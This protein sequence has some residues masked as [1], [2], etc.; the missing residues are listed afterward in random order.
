MAMFSALCAVVP[1][2]RLFCLHVDHGLRAEESKGDAEFV[3]DFCE[4][5]GIGCRVESI[6]HGKIEFYAQHKGI[7]IE[8]A[9][10]H[11]R[12]R[13]LFREAARLGDNTLILIAHTKD[14]LLETALMRVLRGAGPAGL[15][16]MPEKRGRILRPVLS[17]SRS[18]I[19]NYLSEKKIPWRED[20]TNTDEVFLRNKVRRRLVPLLDEFFP[21]WKSGLTGMAATQSLAADYLAGEAKRRIVWEQNKNS[22]STGEENFFAQDIIIREE[23]LFQGVDL[24]V[25][26]CKKI[27]ASS[28]VPK[29]SVV[30]R[31]CAGAVAAADLGLLRVRRKNGVIVLS[32]IRR[33]FS[34]SGFSLLI[35]EPGLYNLNNIGIE[36]RPFYEHDGKN[37]F[38]AA[39][40]L[41]FRQSYKSD[42]LVNR[43][44]KIRRRTLAESRIVSAED[45]M[46]IAAFTGRTGVLAKRDMLPETYNGQVYLVTVNNN[47]RGR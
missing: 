14:D 37:G 29:R 40:P 13:A 47:K 5:N 6:P 33:D 26:L 4:K 25:S 43:G 45:M 44:K 28:S 30:R 8:A 1:K 23:A 42:I 19:I 22:F 21:A 32:P 11:F 41:V 2:E 39:L 17:F 35:K 38:F 7:G 10:R 20:S 15:A 12:R 9:A 3:R 24:L 18:D 27:R 46:G 36:V 34:E 16:V 31:F